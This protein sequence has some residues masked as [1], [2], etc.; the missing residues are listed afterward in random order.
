MVSIIETAVI[1]RKQSQ[2]KRIFMTVLI[3][4]IY[5]IGMSL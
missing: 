4:L 3:K 1:M 5:K 2:A